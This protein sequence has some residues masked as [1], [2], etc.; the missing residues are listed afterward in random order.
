MENCQ[1]NVIFTD[2]NA[3]C[4]YDTKF[5]KNL[6]D[7]SKLNWDCINAQYWSNFHDGKRK[8]MAEVLVPDMIVTPMIL[9]LICKTNKTKDVLK[10]KI[11]KKDFHD[12]IIVDNAYFF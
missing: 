11:I 2:G 12:R 5:Y 7:L 6:D 9:Q 4:R 3:A 1:K 8:H 10:N